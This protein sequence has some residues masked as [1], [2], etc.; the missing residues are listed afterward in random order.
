MLFANENKDARGQRD[1]IEQENG[2]PEIYAKSQQT[3]D[4]QVNREQKH[5]DVFGEFH[6]VNLLDRPLG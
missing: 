3:I 6:G 2:R 1:K 5:A 4:D